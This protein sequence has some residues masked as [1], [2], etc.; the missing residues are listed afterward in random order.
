MKLD[1][2][3]IDY[4]KTRFSEMK[5]RQ[6]LLSLLNYAKP[7][8]YG[9]KTESF[10][11]RQLSYYSNPKNSKK[12][13][14]SFQVKKK[15]GGAR[16]INAPVKGLKALQ[17][18]LSLIFQCVFEPHKAATGFVMGKSIVDNARVHINSN[19]VFNIDLKDFFSSID[20]ARVWSCFKL[21]PFNLI[22]DKDQKKEFSMLSTGIRKFTTVNGEVIFYKI[23]SGEVRLISNDKGDY[24]KYRTR[25]EKEGKD[26]N[27]DVKEY[28]IKEKNIKS[29]SKLLSLRS[30][31]ANILAGIVCTSMEVERMN[32][33]GVWGK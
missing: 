11:L 27:E 25:I 24:K 13:Y 29:L 32:N 8:I 1:K 9:D 20:Q 16:T 12:A 3:Q 6:D 18:V 15:F 22:D 17:K 23:K 26:F 30:N 14:V 4:I 2:K 21:D 33:E 5:S 7:L 31:L 10:E 28:I 19:Y